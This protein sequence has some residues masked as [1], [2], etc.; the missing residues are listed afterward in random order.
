MQKEKLTIILKS[1][2]EGRTQGKALPTRMERQA[3]TGRHGLPDSGAEF[4]IGASC[5]V[6]V[7][8][9]EMELMNSWR[10]KDSR[11]FQC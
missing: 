3:N 2:R 4:S 1:I 10:V 11:E 8:R 7:E 5:R 9:S 6:G